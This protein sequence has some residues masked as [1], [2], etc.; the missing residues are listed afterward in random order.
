KHQSHLMQLT[1]PTPSPLVLLLCQLLFLLVLHALLPPL[2][3]QMGHWSGYHLPRDPCS[4]QILHLVA[5]R[6][7]PSTLPL[8]LS[9]QQQYYHLCLSRNRYQPHPLFLTNCFAILNKLPFISSSLN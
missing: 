5:F 9:H 3:A 7:T 4:T 8:F 2:F 1:S 6:S